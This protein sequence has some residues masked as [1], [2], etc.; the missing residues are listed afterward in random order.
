M[1]EQPGE[2]QQ[3]EL[4]LVVDFYGG[5]VVDYLQ[6]DVDCWIT[7]TEAR[8]D[9]INHQY[10]QPEQF[11]LFRRSSVMQAVRFSRHCFLCNV[12]TFRSFVPANRLLDTICVHL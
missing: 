11:M 9:W 6:P 5:T 8:C 1:D 7:S 12:A 2:H 4:A 10:G 3:N